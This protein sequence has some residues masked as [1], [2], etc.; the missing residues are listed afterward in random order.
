[1]SMNIESQILENIEKAGCRNCK[2]FKG[3]TPISN[4]TYFHCAIYPI[5]PPGE[6]CPD[7]S[8]KQKIMKNKEEKE[9][10]QKTETKPN[11]I[12][13]LDE[14]LTNRLLDLFFKDKYQ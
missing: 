1:M 2:S 10:V 13:I 6:N 8:L 11:L 7:F 5:A 4:N 14:L 3:F 12:N 9:L